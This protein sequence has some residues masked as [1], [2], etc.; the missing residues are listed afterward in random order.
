MRATS[1]QTTLPPLSPQVRRRFSRSLSPSPSPS[2]GPTQLEAERR[3][4]PALS[5]CAPP[6]AHSA[7]QSRSKFVRSLAHSLA[8][9]ARTKGRRLSGLR[10]CSIGARALRASIWRKRAA[11][12]SAAHRAREPRRRKVRPLAR[13]PARRR[14]ILWPI[15]F[16]SHAQAWPM[17]SGRAA[18]LLFR[19]WLAGFGSSRRGRA[20]SGGGE[21]SESTS[22]H[23]SRRANKRRP[24]EPLRLD[25]CFICGKCT[26]KLGQV[27]AK[28]CAARAARNGAL[29]G[30]R[31][32][33]AP[34]LRGRRRL[35]CLCSCFCFCSR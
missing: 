13:P 33:S 22:E 12:R 31:L 25:F 10:R 21:L 9:S 4:G 20:E 7:Y 5:A 28:Y 32:V 27:C 11:R 3:V 15:A 6:S 19:L 23:S 8:C 34:G 14:P 29:Y 30:A 1:E 26:G 16:E 2:A 35:C 18:V 24:P 17:S